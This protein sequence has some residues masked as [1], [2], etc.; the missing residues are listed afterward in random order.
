MHLRNFQLILDEGYFGA[1]STPGFLAHHK[2]RRINIAAAI[3]YEV[4]HCTIL[5][6]AMYIYVLS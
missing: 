3:T 1:D 4:K 2:M 5:K 6:S